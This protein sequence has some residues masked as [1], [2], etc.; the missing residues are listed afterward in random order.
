VVDATTEMVLGAA[1]AR[2]HWRDRFVLEA[3][4]ADDSWT[5]EE[6]GRM[7]G[8]TRQRVQQLESRARRRVRTALERAG[9][10]GSEEADDVER[11]DIQDAKNYMR[12][13]RIAFPEAESK[14]LVVRRTRAEQ[15]Q[16]TFA[17]VWSRGG[18]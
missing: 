7:F 17:Y 14:P 2:L 5:L 10:Y 18:E 3:R 6:L 1:L 9:I 4:A 16:A 12:F 15:R 11:L 8:V 13:Y